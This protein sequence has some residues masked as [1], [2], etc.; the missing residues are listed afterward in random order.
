MSFGE[1]KRIGNVVAE[2][3]C[4]G[5]FVGLDSRLQKPSEDPVLEAESDRVVC[6]KG[7]KVS[8]NPMPPEVLVSTPL[9]RSHRS[10]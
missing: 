7:Y 9:P 8:P 4:A 2:E 10:G 1:S 5:F 6:W 3:N